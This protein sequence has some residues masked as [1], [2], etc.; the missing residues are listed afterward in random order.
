MR[1]PHEQFARAM[2]AGE[3]DEDVDDLED[4]ELDEDEDFDEDDDWDDDDE[5]EEEEEGA[6][7]GEHDAG[8]RAF[9]HLMPAR[10]MDRGALTRRRPSSGRS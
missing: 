5:E 7:G 4:E 6:T 10:P 8:G 3:E 1:D 9:G 2:H